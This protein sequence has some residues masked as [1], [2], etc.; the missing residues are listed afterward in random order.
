MGSPKPRDQRWIASTA[1]SFLSPPI[2]LGVAMIRLCRQVGWRIWLAILSG[3]INAVF[4]LAVILVLLESPE[5]ALDR[6]CCSE[7]QEVPPDGFVCLAPGPLV[8]CEP[9]PLSTLS[10]I[11]PNCVYVVSD[12]IIRARFEFTDETLSSLREVLLA[13]EHG[14]PWLQGDL[15]DHSFIYSQYKN[16]ADT[17]A[18][19]SLRD[20]DGDGVPDVKVDWLLGRSF[21]RLKD[22]EWGEIKR[23]EGG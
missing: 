13:D 4:I 20:T 17:D 21:E 15:D 3:A 9:A 7:I 8:F 16:E 23:P 11:I 14:R 18:E 1:I 22:I 12:G 10:V 6:S 5:D 2:A 19:V